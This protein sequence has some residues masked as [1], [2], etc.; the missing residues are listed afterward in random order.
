MGEVRN[1]TTKHVLAVHHYRGYAQVKLWVAGRVV[2]GW[3]HRLVC[4]AFSGPPP[5]Q[6]DAGHGNHMRSDNKPGNLRWV[7][8]LENEA[9]K[10][11]AGRAW[12]QRGQHAHSV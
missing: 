2:T 12:F 10:I 1:A 3:I 11:A 9:E 5:A 8:R 7:T 6:M 4:E